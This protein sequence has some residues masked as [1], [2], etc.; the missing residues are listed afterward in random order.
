MID[1]NPQAL[2]LAFKKC[3][4]KLLT[5]AKLKV[6][7]DMSEDA[8]EALIETLSE[9][10][11]KEDGVEF[12]SVV[13]GQRWW[14]EHLIEFSGKPVADQLQWE[15]DDSFADTASEAEMLVALDDLQVA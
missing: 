8:A 15:Y 4:R 6:T 14:V 13:S 12:A 5:I 2:A 1:K 7:P 3:K 9:A 10:K 11:A